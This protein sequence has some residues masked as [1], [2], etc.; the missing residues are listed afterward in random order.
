MFHE[1]EF[2]VAISFFVFVGLL[3][4]LKV[5]GMVTK[6][7]DERAEA[8]RKEI[9]EAARMREEAQRL[10]ARYDA[11]RKEA[12]KE[13]EEIL[14][15]AKQ[16]AEAVVAE[17]RHK[18]EEMIAR[19][20]ASAEEKIAQVAQAAAQEVRGRAAELSVS[21]AEDLLAARIKGAKA[22]K[23]IDESLQAVKE[24]LH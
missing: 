22:T 4:Y 2:W 15:V 18:F 20:K 7:L 14:A 8:I 11:K 13:A 3:L 23:L 5:P 24:K 12:E 9:E 16:E 10:L 21:V 1:P 19:K 17:A 6:A